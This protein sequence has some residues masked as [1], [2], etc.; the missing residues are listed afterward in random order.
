M[1]ELA[2]IEPQYEVITADKINEYMSTFGIA[3][4][5]KDNEK[6]QFIEI[7][8]AYQ[9]NPFKRE[10]YCVAYG[11]NQYRKLSIITG[12]ETYL[13]RA[14][15]TGNLDGWEAEIEGSGNEMCAKL[16]IYRKDWTHPFIH[17]AYWEECKQT[18]YDSTAK[19]HKLNAIWDKMGKFMLRKVAIAQGFRLC[20][21]DELGGM[22]YTA[23]ELPENMTTPMP[24]NTKALPEPEKTP[25][26]IDVTPD[27][28]KRDAEQ[29]PVP[30]TP[31]GAH[32]LTEGEV[33]EG[34]WYWNLKAEQKAQYMPAGCSH[35][36]VDGRWICSKIQ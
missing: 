21:P 6:K 1:N 11:Q 31:E 20:F 15:R 26:P 29:K 30:P 32:M 10:I 24:Q 13:K 9:L 25:P 22:P 33:I 27:A 2:K 5:L 23:D 8:T 17:R 28:L 4:G 7:A 12:Y 18:T 3:D 36:K 19:I 16:T 35:V 14:E 34:K